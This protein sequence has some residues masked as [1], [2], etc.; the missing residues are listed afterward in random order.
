ME[1]CLIKKNSQQLMINISL[2]QL[3]PIITFWFV[4]FNAVVAQPTCAV[5]CNPL[6]TNFLLFI[7]FLCFPC[8]W[9]WNIYCWIQHESYPFNSQL[10]ILMNIVSV[11]M[12]QQSKANLGLSCKLLV[13]FNA[14]QIE[15]SYMINTMSS[16]IP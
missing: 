4:L 13:I 5:G 7:P 16:K 3:F 10:Y 14:I 11:S 6:F 12:S 2:V 8:F 15:K 1:L 9:V